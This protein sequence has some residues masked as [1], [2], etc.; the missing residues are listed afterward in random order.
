V[1]CTPSDQ[2]HFAGTCDPQT[3]CSNPTVPDGTGCDDGSACTTADACGGGAC[4]GTPGTPPGLVTSVLA[5]KTGVSADFGW[6]AIAGATAYDILR[7]RVHDWPVGSNPGTETCFGDLVA[8]TGSDAAVPIAGDG[9]WYLIRAENV[10]G[11]GGYGFEGFH[12]VPTVPRLSGT[13][14]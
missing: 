10:C 14:P 13:C 1:F 11:N 6:D 5:S 3:G 2:C 4:A 8:T 7:G 12:G 9:Y